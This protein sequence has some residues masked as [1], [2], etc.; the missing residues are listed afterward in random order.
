MGAE[1]WSEARA[2]AA[3][4]AASSCTLHACARPACVSA[5]VQLCSFW[6][7]FFIKL[8]CLPR[9]WEGY[10]DCSSWEMRDI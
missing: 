1:G 6:Y 4:A 10:I 5:C 7:L 2:A 9:V 8:Q 3:A